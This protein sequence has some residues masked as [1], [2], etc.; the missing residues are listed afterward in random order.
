VPT[1]VK[2]GFVVLVLSGCGATFEPRL[3]TGGTERPPSP[4]PEEYVGPAPSPVLGGESDGRSFIDLICRTQPMPSGWIAVRYEVGGD[5]CPQPTGA[6][7]PFTVAMI[8][9]YTG[10]AIGQ[11]MIV[12]ADQR[13]PR[14]WVRARNQEASAECPGARVRPDAPTAFVIRRLR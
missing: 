1:R 12:C 14:N 8:E 10:K 11:T 13:L 5:R 2:L 7:N 4:Y 6:G 9:R 3:G